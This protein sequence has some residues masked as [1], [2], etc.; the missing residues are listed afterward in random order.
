MKKD[1]IKSILE[2]EYNKLQRDDFLAVD[3][4]GIAYAF[5][6]KEDI[7]ISAFFAATLA[8][9]RREIII[10]N[11]LKILDFMDNEPFDFVMNFKESDLRPI[12]NFVHRT[13]N[14]TDA[15]FFIRALR[16]VYRTGGLEAAFRGQGIK[17]RLIHLHHAFFSFEWSLER[18]R[19]HL[20]NPAKGSA[21]KRL[22]M[23]LRW[24]VRRDKPDLGLWKSIDPSEL[25]CPL[26][27]H[28]Q[29][30]ALKLGLLRRKQQ[31]WRAVEELSDALRSLDPIDPIKYDLPLF[32]LSE[33]G[34]LD[35]LP[36]SS[37][38]N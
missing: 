12:E 15:I 16:E 13:F 31:D 28:V 33:T 9:G 10:S 4:L 1:Q 7:E 8:W 19:K 11:C 3:P 14:G 36:A 26:D 25:M 37:S 24:M 23:F 22:N 35:Q 32:V 5:D 2:S 27:V 21:A 34:R 17:N 38:L 29:R 30:S 18:S 6:R 20:A